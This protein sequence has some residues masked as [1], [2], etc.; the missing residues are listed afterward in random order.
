MAEESA[1][2]DLD[3]SQ[4]YYLKEQYLASLQMVDDTETTLKAQLDQIVKTRKQLQ[5]MMR[6]LD[7]RLAGETSPTTPSKPTP[8]PAVKPTPRQT[9]RKRPVP[10]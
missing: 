7:A 5:E 8:K 9:T 2:A 4:L 6:E 10:M 1:F 3:D